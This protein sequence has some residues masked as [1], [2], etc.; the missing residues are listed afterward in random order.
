MIICILKFDVPVGW[1]V[2]W[3]VGWFVWLSR[4]NG[5]ADQDGLY[6]KRTIPATE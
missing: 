3:L 4:A 1:L 6:V 5:K 2:R